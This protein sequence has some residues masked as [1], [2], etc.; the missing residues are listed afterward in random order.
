[1]AKG[2]PLSHKDAVRKGLIYG[3]YRVQV[4]ANVSI[5]AAGAAIGF[6]SLAIDDI[7]KGVF[8]LRAAT[9]A[10]KFTKLDGNLIATW[11]G[12]WSIGSALNV[13]TSLTST[14]Q[15]IIPSTAIGPATAGV[16]TGARVTMSTPA[17][18]PNLAG[19]SLLALNM[20]ANAADITDSTTAVV[21][22]QGFLDLQCG[23]LVLP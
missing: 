11:S 6:G 1:M 17:V 5:A 3:L 10:F 13:D 14:D 8:D 4:N 12:N 2:L 7:P 19:A 9:A 22:V 16:I 23:F 15:D 20:L 18:I 21:K